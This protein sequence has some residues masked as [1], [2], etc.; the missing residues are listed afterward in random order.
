MGENSNIIKF[1]CTTCNGTGV[2]PGENNQICPECMGTGFS[3]SR[4][5]L[6]VANIISK[7]NHIKKVVDDIYDKVK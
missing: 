7:L 4:L 1:R 2:C 3:D 5:E 6:D